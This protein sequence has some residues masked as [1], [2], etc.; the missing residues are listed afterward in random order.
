MMVLISPTAED[1]TLIST[2]NGSVDHR[3]LPR[4]SVL[5]SGRCRDFSAWTRRSHPEG[6]FVCI[7]ELLSPSNSFSAEYVVSLGSLD[8]FESRMDRVG[9]ELVKTLSG[10][11]QRR[12]IYMLMTHC[13]VEERILNEFVTSGLYTVRLLSP[14]HI[15]SDAYL[16]IRPKL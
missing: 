2:T 9:V 15:M 3:L 8:E 11:M 16:I 4:D 1:A 5:L 13:K 12:G 14:V 7:R 10:A 6:T